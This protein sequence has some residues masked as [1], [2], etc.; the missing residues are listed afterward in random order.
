MR[1]FLLGLAALSLLAAPAPATARTAKRV[2]CAKVNYQ[3]GGGYYVYVSSKIRGTR[4]R[5]AT[6]RRV[7]RVKPA[8]VSG[9]G[10]ATRKFK[11]GKFACKGKARKDAKGR[12]RVAF[13]CKRGRSTISF[14]WARQ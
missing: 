11:S 3:T 14:T 8:S 9:T 2:S 7:A 4:V 6:A 5:C 10:T 1:R 13:R 12:E